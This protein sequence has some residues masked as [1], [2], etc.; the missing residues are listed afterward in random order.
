MSWLTLAVLLASAASAQVI[1]FES[2]GLKF[3]TLTRSGLTIMFAH[4]PVHVRGYAMIQVAVSNG[5]S[6]PCKIRP[7]DFRFGLSD[8]SI[9]RGVSANSVISQFVRGASA[10]DVIKL[11][12][13]YEMGLYGMGRIR[14]T[15]SYEK[16]RQAALA[17]VSSK[18]LKAAAAA[19]AIAFVETELKPGESTDGAVFYPIDGRPMSQATLKVVAAGRV[20]EFDSGSQNFERQ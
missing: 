15:N 8:N 12:T 13:T 4:M 20:F 16:R 3:Q 7:Q 10:D 18:R 6:G 14:F 5:S 11:V 1:E 2:G 19:S 17:V 9:I